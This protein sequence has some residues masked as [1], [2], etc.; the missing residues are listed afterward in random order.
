[1]H[2]RVLIPSL[3]FSALLA[4]PA[5]ADAHQPL[6]RNGQ[7]IFLVAP[8]GTMLDYV[9]EAGTVIMGEDTFGHRILLDY[10]GNLVATELTAREYDSY[11]TR[12]GG[13]PQNGNGRAFGTAFDRRGDNFDDYGGQ[14]DSRDLAPPRA[15][16]PGSYQR[17]GPDTTAAPKAAIS[18]KPDMKVV[19]LQVLLDREGFSP[20]VIDGRMGDNVRKALAAYEEATGLTLDPNDSETIMSDLSLG[21]GL[22]FQSYTITAKDAAG[23]Y[24]AAIP[25]D[26]SEKA[27]LPA[28]SYTSVAE[29][30]AEKFHMDQNFLRSLNPDADF[31]RPGTVIKVINPGAP[32]SGKVATIIADKGRKQVRAYDADGALIVAYPATIGSSDTPS[33]SGTVT[34]ERI[35]IDPSYTYNPSKNFK[36]GDNDKVLTI[37][38]GP[39]GPVGDVWIALSKPTYGIH[40]TPDPEKIGKTSSH[41]C[42]RLTN[43]DATELAHMVS[44]GVTVTFTD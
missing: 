1:M 18:S 17:Q 25:S 34:V 37:N 28:M 20:G 41:G 8:N 31:T 36:Q 6:Y 32:K 24:V 27:Q 15:S 7:Q 14:I 44:P 5:I 23:P 13:S 26:Y 16:E 4:L 39:N 12:N 33:P 3:F 2:L 29:M 11:A 19:A 10:N 30:L 38:P 9:P 40:G 22:P 43:W 21:G 35:A 42:V